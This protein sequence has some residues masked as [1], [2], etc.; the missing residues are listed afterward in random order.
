MKEQSSKTLGIHGGNI[1]RASEQYGLPAQQ[2]LDFSANINP[3]GLAPSVKTALFAHIDDVINYPDP[4]AVLCKQAIGTYYNLPVEE[5][6]LGNGAVE[7]IHLLTQMLRPR[8]ALIPAPTFSEYERA[9]RGTEGEIIYFPLR[10]EEDFRLDTDAFISSL[11]TVNMCFICNPNNPVGNVIQRNDLQKI[12]TAAADCGVWV[13][14]DESF[15]DFLPQAEEITCRKMVADYQNLIVV[16]SLTKFFAIPG[17]RLGFGVM[18]RDVARSLE[19]AKDPWNVNVLAQA[20][21]VAALQDKTYISKTLKTIRDE[22]DFLFYELNKIAGIT[23]FRPAVNFVFFR[24]HHPQY[25]VAALADAAARKGILIRDCSS[26]A[27]LAEGYIRVAVKQRADNLR[28]LQ[29][30]RELLRER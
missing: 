18:P 12:V 30:L 5:L 9:V 24:L 27:G 10:A 7:L 15:V 17:L 28:L 2:W 19:F 3:F 16:H 22:K 8:K 21:A 14:I 20:A 26:Y 29:V 25:S 23:A 4:E 13:I 1:R 11:P 6:V